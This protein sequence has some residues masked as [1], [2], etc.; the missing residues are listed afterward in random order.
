[1]RFGFFLV[2]SLLLVGFAQVAFLAEPPKKERGDE[3][4]RLKAKL[5]GTWEGQSGCAGTLQV[6]ADG[7]YELTQ[8]GP[9]GDDS[10][11]QWKIRWDALPPTLILTCKS[12][13]IEE[14]VG[15]LRKLKLLQLDD[16][17]LVIKD[18]SPDALRYSRTQKRS[19]DPGRPRS[20]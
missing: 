15:S 4:A 9:G 18:A 11:G 3:L 17:D 2:A 6:R 12:S 1:M 5:F 16:V 19:P 14:E 10:T 13:Q 7:T 20:Q 8:F